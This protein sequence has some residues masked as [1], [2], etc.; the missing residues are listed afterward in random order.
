ML[1]NGKKFDGKLKVLK[2]LCKK[3]GSKVRYNEYCMD[4]R[5]HEVELDE[6]ILKKY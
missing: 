4:I 5:G 1:N 6:E 3:Y 2:Y